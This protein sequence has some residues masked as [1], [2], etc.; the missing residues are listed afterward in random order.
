[1]VRG[2]TKKN[3][4]RK[5]TREAILK[6]IAIR[7][8]ARECKSGY[9]ILPATP[10]DKRIMDEFCNQ[11]GN[12]YITVTASIQRGNKTYDQVKTVWAL[13]S[14]LCEAINGVKPTTDEADR[15]YNSLIDEY[16]EREVDIRHPKRTIPI[17]L[18][19]MSV[20]QADQFIQAIISEVFSCVQ[21]DD[22]VQGN[23]EVDVKEI[24][25]QFEQHKGLLEKD[26][27]DY[28]KDGNLLSVDEWAKSHN[29]SMASGLME[30]LEIAHIVTKAAAPQ[31][32]DCCWN[33]LRLTHYEHIEI[34]H[35]KGWHELLSIY[36]HLIPRVK[37]AYQWAKHLN[38]ADG[39]D[40]FYTE[41]DN[42]LKDDI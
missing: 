19:K 13:V 37:R 38:Q 5:G 30:G 31:F 11:V 26:P 36:P 20:A 29:I 16:A 18:S 3:C 35:R 17:T 7:G 6:K 33:F 41:L 15:I 1:M 14:I 8:V 23:L 42:E 28:D 21:F 39:L 9:L 25:Q 10:Q 4:T 24:F 27:S 2:S 40:P 12:R 32:R 22:N 34:Q